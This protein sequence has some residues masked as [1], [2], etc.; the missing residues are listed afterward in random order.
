MKKLLLALLVGGSFGL[1]KA[2]EMPQP[3]PAAT[4]I[5]RV[6]LTDVEIT[7]SRPGVKGRDIFGALVPYGEIWRTGANA[8]TKVKFSTDVTINGEN[9]AAGTYSFYAIPTEGEWTMILNT[10]L[11]HWG[12]DGYS[13]DEDAVR[14]NV[15]SKPLNDAVENVRISVENITKSSGEITLSWANTS[16][17]VPFTVE[18][19]EQIE[20]NVN[21]S[22]GDAMRAYRASANLAADKGDYVEAIEDIDIAI[23]MN[24][25]NWYTQ[26]LK[27]EIYAKSG[28]YKKAIKQGEMAIDMG[29]AYYTEANRPF[30]Y[31]AGLEKSLDEWKEKK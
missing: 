30:T 24:S 12:T 2:Q 31:K 28:D 20:K 14:L 13:Q 6:G 5:Q 3:S 10:N 19:D 11:N 17:A 21:K 4:S 25:T 18:V 26:W 22:K 23:A 7:Y 16:V 9:L 15:A 29:D 8:S 1:A 27:A